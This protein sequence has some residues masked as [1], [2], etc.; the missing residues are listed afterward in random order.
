MQIGPGQAPL[1]LAILKALGTQSA[2]PGTVSKVVAGA[3]APGG[4]AKAAM[5][6]PGGDSAG[7]SRPP[8]GS[9][10]DLRV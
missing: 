7:A 3:A 8:R 1:S 6:A 4:A 9:F 2:A 10:L 5:A